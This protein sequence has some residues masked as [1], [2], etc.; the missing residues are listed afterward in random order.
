MTLSDER[1]EESKSPSSLF[2]L[3]AQD[4]LFFLYTHHMMD[5]GDPESFTPGEGESGASEQAREE[6]RQRFAGMA[7]ALQQLRRDEKKSR[8]RDDSIAQTILQ[9]LTDAQRTH[10]ATLIS[11]LVGLNC[12]ST[13][14]L[15]ILS[16]INQDCRAIVI[17]YL[18]ETAK[19]REDLLER[20]HMTL[21]ETGELS[22]DANRLLIE[23]VARMDVVLASDRRN[24]LIS[25]LVSDKNID[26]TVLQLATFVLQDFL[27]AQGKDVAFGKLQPLAIGILHSLFEPHLREYEALQS[28]ETSENA[29]ND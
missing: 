8:R 26:G 28:P 4:I 2:V 19:E 17:E 9:F 12:P 11:R 14:I 21:V 20:E 10:L 29:D 16:L 22:A 25:L 24:I 27:R 23:W 3:R 13:F 6:A 15:A 1:S 7:A 18:K 5:L